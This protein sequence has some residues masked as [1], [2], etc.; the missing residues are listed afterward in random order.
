MIK[1]MIVDDEPLAISVIRG[2]LQEHKDIVIT[3]E[4]LNG[5]EAMKA[6]NIEKPDLLFLDVQMPKISGFELLELLDPAPAVIFVTAFHEHAVQAFEKHAVDY[7]LKPVSR[8]RFE[9]AMQK[10][11]QHSRSSEQ[12][13]DIQALSKEVTSELDRIVIRNGSNLRII[14]LSDIYCFE[15]YDDYVKVH[16]EKETL[17]KKH[18]L[19]ALEERLDSAEFVRVHRSYIV[20]LDAITRIEPLGK[21]THLAVL[22][23]GSKVNL[24]RSGY[25]RLKE[26]LDL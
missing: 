1:V 24:S 18:T 9:A 5:F 26:V 16:L 10:F 23:N 6:I 22:K 13:L 4:C 12:P 21:D 7:L 17:I 19:S 8:E 11:R 25:S 20:R 15:A 2:Y 14:N 3:A